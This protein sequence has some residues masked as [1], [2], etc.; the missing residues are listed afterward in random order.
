MGKYL[1][2]LTLLKA[3]KEDLINGMKLIIGREN[4]TPWPDVPDEDVLG[5]IE[6]LRERPEVADGTERQNRV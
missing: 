4:G 2:R 1:A 3:T 5:Y 6:F